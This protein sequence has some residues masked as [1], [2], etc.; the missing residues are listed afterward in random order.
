MGTI[1]GRGGARIKE[2]Q[3]NTRTKMFFDDDNENDSVRICVIRG[4]PDDVMLA[5]A[6]IRNIISS[7]PVEEC[8]HMY[9]PDDAVGKLIGID[10]KNIRLIQ[11][12]TKT[13]IILDS[14]PTMR[15]IGKE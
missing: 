2:I 9:I 12:D 15:D 4:K 3:A 13:K 8:F 14:S 11:R 1:I 6:L 10:G 5:E 7:Q